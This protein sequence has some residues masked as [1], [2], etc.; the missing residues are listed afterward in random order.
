MLHSWATL[1]EIFIFLLYPYF[2]LIDQISHSCANIVQ[3]AL[4]I[5]SASGGITTTSVKI[6]TPS[7]TRDAG[8]QF[9]RVNNDIRE[10]LL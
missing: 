6:P 7:V 3:I 1:L 8:T 9:V 10:T 5:H 4:S 2:L